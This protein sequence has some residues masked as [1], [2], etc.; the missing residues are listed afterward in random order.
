MGDIVK[1]YGTILR[2]NPMVAKQSEHFIVGSVSYTEIKEMNIPKSFDGRVVWK[3]YLSGIKDQGYCGMCYSCS[4]V[5]SLADR[6]AILSLNQ[7]HTNLSA[8]DMVICMTITPDR[9]SEWIAVDRKNTDTF[10]RQQIKTREKFSCNGNTLYNAGKYLFIIGTT[11]EDCIPDSI[12]TSSIDSRNTPFCEDVEGADYDLCLDRKTAQ[13]FY[14][15]GRIYQ[16]KY[17]ETDLET[18][19]QNIMYDIYKWGPIAAGFLVYDD[20]LNKYDGK[21]IYTTK[22]YGEAKLGHAVKIVGWGE[23]IIS[24]RLVKYWICANSWGTKWGLNGYFKIERFLP[25]L[26]LEKNTL[27]LI[28]ELPGIPN[29]NSFDTKGYITD[30]DREYRR[31]I[32]VSLLYLYPSSAID[33]ID[34]GYIEGDLIDPIINPFNLPKDYIKFV[35]GRI[36]KYNFNYIINGDTRIN[37]SYYLFII[38]AFIVGAVVTYYILHIRKNRSYPKLFF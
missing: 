36:N 30:E 16:I 29:L 31:L 33:K 38:I 12:V 8:S 15:A 13:R 28:P 4:S 10:R 32:G 7:V 22:G 2:N 26:D 17:D 27:S 37:W 24:E 20:F 14:R 9:D 25:G 1:S 5:G 11:S 23:T 21:T 6:F 34:A 19:E 18:V 35:A 3:A